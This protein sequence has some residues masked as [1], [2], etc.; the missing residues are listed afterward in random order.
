MT[1]H[2]VFNKGSSKGFIASIPWGGHSAPNSTVGDK[3]LDF[4]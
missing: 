4:D 2:T 3:A 1:R